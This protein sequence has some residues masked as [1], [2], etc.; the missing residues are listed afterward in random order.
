MK[1]LILVVIILAVLAG[2]AWFGFQRFRQAQA[3]RAMSNLQ[4]VSASRGNLV[5]TIG[6]TGTVR[7]NQTA[8]LIWKTSGSVEQVNVKAGEPAKK[9]QILAT[10]A[11]TSL[12]QNVIQAQAD[13]A[14]A[15]K[16]LEDLYT[17][18]QKSKTEAMQAV[19]TYAKQARDAQYQLD[20]FSVPSNQASLETMEAVNLMKDR[21]DQARLAFEPYKYAS[22]SDPTREDLKEKLDEAQSDYDTAIRR[23]EYENSLAAARFNLEK[24]LNDY[25]KWKNGPNVDDIEAAQA[26]IAAAEAALKQAWIEAPFDGTIT[27][28]NPKPGDQV[29]ANTKAFRLD[30]LSHLFV[31]VQVSEVDIN[32]IRTGQD[33]SLTFDA[34]PDKEYQGTISEVAEVG[35][36]DQGVVEFKVTVELIDPDEQVRPGMTAAA[37]ILIN[38]V[39]DVLVVPNR[40][41]RLKD[42]QRVV[43]LMKNGQLTPVKITLG[44]TSEM[45]SEV[46][47][48]DVQ[49]GDL[50]VLN[51]PIEFN[52]NGP[53]PFVNR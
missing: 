14:N 26:R 32:K 50:I 13:L 3:A 33:V 15:R 52:Q 51:P 11:Q 47:S 22:E 17:N 28:A 40:A 36:E 6:A 53:P 19:S 31:D 35:T 16:A 37:N 45:M 8:D 39:E 12:L 44:A 42:G 29:T 24:S 1:K 23:L 7:A 4:T 18:A 10:L 41:V 2:A 34:I 25:E 9:D 38:E 49:A 46:L 30:D 20:N 48:G 21:L 5:A 43:Y 27:V